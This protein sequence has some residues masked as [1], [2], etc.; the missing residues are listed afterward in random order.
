MRV[1]LRLGKDRGTKTGERVFNLSMGD[2]HPENVSLVIWSIISIATHER[3]EPSSVAM[4]SASRSV[5]R[6][7]YRV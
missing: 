2:S 3:T 7:A 6:I 4:L 1:G 5:L